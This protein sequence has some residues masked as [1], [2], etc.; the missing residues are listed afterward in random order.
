MEALL[1]SLA[2]MSLGLETTLHEWMDVLAW[3]KLYNPKE[4]EGFTCGV[5]HLFLCTTWHNIGNI[6]ESTQ[7]L[8]QALDVVSEKQPQSLIPGIVTYL[9]HDVSH[10][11]RVLVR[12]GDL[13]YLSDSD[14]LW[15]RIL[16][17]LKFPEASDR[18]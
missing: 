8:Y 9:F 12:S 2:R 1:I 16:M 11:A 10:Q 5:V 14:K 6:K 18:S 3:N 15:L 13:D 17:D 7:S 4:Q